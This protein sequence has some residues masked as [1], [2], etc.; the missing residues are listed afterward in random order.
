MVCCVYGEILLTLTAET[1][2]PMLTYTNH[3]RT[4]VLPEYGRN[5]QNMVDRCLEIEDRQERTRAAQSVV[6]TMLTLFPVTGDRTEYIR[7]LWDHVMIMSGFKLD[8]DLPCERVDPTVF[9][10]HPDPIAMP[11]I[12]DGKFRQYGALVRRSI[13]LA[14][15]LPEGEDR[16]E[17]IMLTANQMKKILVE[18]SRDSVEDAV[19]FADIRA[20]SHGGILLDTSLH[21]LHDFRPSPKP[22]SKKKKKK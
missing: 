11:D 7:K 3:L 22:T 13:D 12:P 14:C 16:D 5:I 10:D 1:K 6:D 9:E 20:M 2:T 18:S 19:V 21:V 4:L 17:L 8:V 15:Q